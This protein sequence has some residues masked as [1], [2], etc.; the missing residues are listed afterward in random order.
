MYISNDVIRSRFLYHSGVFNIVLQM[1]YRTLRQ[2]A[3][4]RVRIYR[5]TRAQ[6]RSGTP[7]DSRVVIARKKESK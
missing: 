4:S 3:N 7:G 6:R 5:S 2:Y 1:P